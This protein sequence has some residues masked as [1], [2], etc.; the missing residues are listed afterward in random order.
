MKSK[1]WHKLLS[2]SKVRRII[3][4]LQEV[5]LP[6]FQKNSIYSVGKFFIASIKKEGIRLRSSSMAYSF[7]L[8]IFPSILFILTLVAFIPIEGLKME[9]FSQLKLVMPKDAFTTIELTVLDILVNSRAEILSLGF[10]SF[11][12]FA[13]NGIQSMIDAFNKRYET[14]KKGFFLKN[15][16][17]SIG[18]T[19][20]LAFQLIIGACIII[21]SSTLFNWLEETLGLN[22]QIV[23]FII[24]SIKYIVLFGIVL[25]TIS[26]LYHF[27]SNVE[28][29]YKFVSPGALLSTILCLLTTFFFSFYV[30]NFG[31]YNKIYGSL[32]AIIGLLIL[33]YI[34]CS[35]IL[36]GYEL[37]AS[38][39]E[40]D[41]NND[42]NKVNTS[43]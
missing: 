2:F 42:I 5:S 24:N 23:A 41:S 7:F 33:I 14:V 35:S 20:F 30:D 32:G 8:A 26:A 1:F 3:S 21:Y 38:I 28:T 29:K 39:K 25:A 43:E 40:A 34:N 19:L 15:R 13:S 36:V 9:I 12:Y 6:G 27:C 22:H 37:N 16:L 11:I 31:S 10:L 18:I 4:Y 17:K